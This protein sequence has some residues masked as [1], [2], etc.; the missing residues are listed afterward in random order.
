MNEKSPHFA[1]LVGRKENDILSALY[2]TAM[3]DRLFFNL[4][5]QSVGVTPQEVVTFL[6]EWSVKEHELG[7]CRDPD[8]KFESHNKN[9]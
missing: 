4:A 8:C 1:M 2:T 9:I 5:V 3:R 6:R 7:W